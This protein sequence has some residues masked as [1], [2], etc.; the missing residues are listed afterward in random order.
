[1]TGGVA[2]VQARIAEI[3]TRIRMLAGGVSFTDVLSRVTSGT[4]PGSYTASASYPAAFAST[5]AAS[6]SL[7]FN[8]PAD[9]EKVSR[10]QAYMKSRNFNAG[11][12]D[13]AATFASAAQQYGMD[14]RLGVAIAVAESSGGR[15][16]FRQNNPFGI[17]G[18]SFAS[19]KDAV[20]EVNRLVASYGFGN[21]P[22]KILAKYNPGGGEQYIDNVIKEMNAV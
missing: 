14:W 11:L 21:D 18:K 7:L 16:C 12:A 6:T 9:P 20:V 5:A 10:L 19:F 17:M 3:E 4:G 2:A 1:M 22:R 13:Q 15:E 8:N